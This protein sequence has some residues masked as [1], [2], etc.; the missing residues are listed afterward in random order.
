M[1]ASL[2]RTD[3]LRERFL[4]AR[5]TLLART[6]RPSAA[7]R[8][9]LTSLTDRWLGGLFD[10]SGAA[11]AG[12][13]LVAIGGHGRRE[14]AAGS[15]LD[16]LLLHPG[17]R[18]SEVADLIWY[19]IW[20]SGVRL[21][22]SVRTIPEARRLASADL[23]V[24]LGLLDARLIAGD[25]SAVA[26]LTSSILADWRG[27]AIKRLGELAGTVD[28]RREQ[29]GELAYLLEPDLKESYGGLRDLTVLRA[30]A[31]S[32]VSDAPHERLAAPKGL[33]LDVR[34][35][36]HR[37]TP[38]PTD[39]LAKQEH[40]PVA[41]VLG[42][43]DADAMLRAV[44]AAGRTIAVASESTWYAVHRVT[45]AR[46]LLGFTRLTQ[47]GPQRTPLAEGVVLQDGE[48]VLAAEARPDRDP[49]LILRAAA[50]AAQRGIRLGQH[51]LNRLAAES[52]PLPVPWPATAR[53]ALVSL[54]GAGKAAVPVWE[55][56][57]QAGVIADLIPHWSQVRSAP[58][59]NAVHRHTVD[60][61]LLEAAVQATDLART[62]SRPDLLL[63]AALLHD[64]G[65]GRAT[66]ADPGG[67]HSE[68]GALLVEEIAAHMGFSA[69]DVVRLV[70]LVRHHLL[71]AETATRRDLDDPATI[72]AVSA[73]VG[74]A[75]F[76]DLLGALTE[77]D[78]IA[79]G[80]LAWTAWKRAL[81]AD[82]VNRVR[83]ELAGVSVPAPPQLSDVQLSLAK[84]SGVRVLMRQTLGG[85]EVS[86]GAPDR[87]GL[88]GLVAGVLSMHRLAIR[89]ALTVSVGD[90][91]VE[92]WQ[93]EPL[94]GDPPEVERLREDINRALAGHLNVSERLAR[95]AADSG[96]TIET[97][98]P[99][100][101][102]VPGASARATV[103]EVRAHDTAGL[104]H[105][106]GMAI[107]HTGVDI[108]AARV[109]TLGSEV[110]DVFY[111][112]DRRG[113]PLAQDLAEAVVESVARGLE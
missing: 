26:K 92:V 66:T 12:A 38:R 107:A 5:T 70:H 55:A 73:L 35:A 76:L 9:A 110:V 113:E 67:S 31:A 40:G 47:R 68:V 50:V 36:L 11:E 90:R 59:H 82:L 22:H 81:V 58:Q 61:H 29:F 60:R 45:R 8:A 74:D 62:V 89:S 19:P 88:L 87:L 30:I 91:A 93:V 20:D 43:P 86:L 25:P 16:L 42:F 37:V 101:E 75:E 78:A 28:S 97:S 95:R 39:R 7:S 83:G 2:T 100:I 17:G 3:E 49:V 54:L 41:E 32:W 48:A 15:D 79:T 34:D 33:L 65:K 111:V 105:K 4:A 109:S 94:F 103:L 10:N 80:P 77:A 106:I 27:L 51:T 1:E 52:A 53:D 72:A 57:D 46:P 69:D 85:W 96:E 23:R 71:L 56:L 98:P 84:G 99:R 104:L 13:S 64:I 24:M 108:T 44:S 102:L 112:V 6:D 18:M 14:L 63:V 21:D